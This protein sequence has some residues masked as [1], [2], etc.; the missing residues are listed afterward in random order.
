MLIA[1]DRRFVPVL[2]F[3]MICAPA[4]AWAQS[5][6]GAVLGTVSDPS[7]AVIPDARVGLIN[8]ATNQRA[9]T[10]SNQTGY[11]EFPFVVPGRYRVEVS[12]K[13]FK[14]FI[15]DEI[16]VLVDQRANLN[17]SLE[18]GAAAEKV[19]V[20]A[21]TPLLGVETGSLGGV[22][23]ERDII[24]LPLNTRQVFGLAMLDAG[25]TP[26]DGGGG[27]G[28]SFN[29]AINFSAGGAIRQT[30]KV[31][32]D[33]IDATLNV[34]N[35][36][37][38]GV[39]AVPSV[40]SVQEFKIQSNSFSAE[41][42]RAGGVVNVVMK[43]GS[44]SLHGTLYEFLRNSAMDANNFFANARG[45]AL[46]V[47]RRNQFGGT[48]GGPVLLPHVYNGKDRSFFFFSAEALR[49]SSASNTSQRTPT[50]LERNGDFSQTYTQTGAVIQIFDPASL[51][52][53][54][55]GASV[56]QA[57]P[58]NVIPAERISRVSRNMLAS[59]PSP[60]NPGTG[61]AHI[62]N[63]FVTASPTTNQD[64]YDAKFDQSVGQGD[65]LSVKLSR[66]INQSVNPKISQT[67]G[68]G[69]YSEEVST[70]TSGIE[71]TRMV[72]PNVIANLSVGFTR[73]EDPRV[74]AS[75]GFQVASLGMPAAIDAVA[76]HHTYPSVLVSNYVQ[77]G[78]T[79][80]IRS[81]ITPTCTN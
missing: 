32:V 59:Y 31:L 56:R 67:P 71:Y 60:N 74:T 21:T 76:S 42:G 20:T 64:H 52:T 69:G 46:P 9:Q 38:Q 78:N 41:Y 2:V 62:G 15:R 77:L 12:A 43:S 49:A 18:L 45:I 66:Y 1:T 5:S 16:A 54:A 3:L 70:Y 65:R 7:G 40:N 34:N 73:L 39:A 33:G 63:F 10:A 30:A 68:G 25:V 81:T 35:T 61:P 72:R 47:Y 37:L 6:T 75:D 22:I 29:N 13:G 26:G 48:L 4:A 55:S 36:S 24:D 19:E 51:T 11:Y 50:D 57:F 8:L 79:Q 17:V 80:D 58:G 27:P 23:G 28:G 14:T 53:N 44:N